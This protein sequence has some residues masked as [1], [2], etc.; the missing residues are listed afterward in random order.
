MWENNY[1]KTDYERIVKF[2]NENSL[3]NY[4]LIKEDKLKFYGTDE[5]N[6]IEMDPQINNV[7]DITSY[8]PTVNDISGYEMDNFD[9][10]KTR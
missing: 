6:K 8:P 5:E 10:P 7:D 4:S 3:N 9:S 1:L 2:A